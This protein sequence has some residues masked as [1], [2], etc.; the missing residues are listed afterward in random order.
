MEVKKLCVL[1]VGNIGYQIA[2]LAAQHGYE[3]TL[4]DIEEKIVQDGAQKINDGLKRFFVDKGKMTQ[5]EAD[6]T[7]A[8]ITFTT[9]LKEATKDADLVIE[10]VP[11]NMEL[12]QQ[13]FKELD[14]I[15]LPHI[16]LTSNSSALAVTEIS[17]LAKRKDKVAGL[18]FSNPPSVLN[19]LEIRRCLNT[20]DETIDTLRDLGTKLDQEII[21][22]KDFPGG[23]AR[24]LNVQMNEAI[25]LIE[26]GVCTPEDI[27]KVTTKALGHRWGLMEVADINLELP[28]AALSYL[29]KELGDAYAPAPLLKQMVLSGRTGRKV[30]KGFYDYSK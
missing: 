2:Q 8:R 19:L 24:L 1:G 11:E 27:D 12:K 10:S 13:V 28:Y 9:D 4:R 14:E 7:L 18:H 29:Q 17:A 25:K 16:I 6:K 23:F 30:G 3:V 21:V 5:E 22:V 15:C 26:A 20:S